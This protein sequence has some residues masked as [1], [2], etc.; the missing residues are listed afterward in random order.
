MLIS[1]AI[2]IMPDVAKLTRS[3][4]NNEQWFL[5]SEAETVV[6]TM[7]V[8]LIARRYHRKNALPKTRVKAK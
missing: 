2:L 1:G 6:R 3:G 8:E 5:P 4:R 7:I